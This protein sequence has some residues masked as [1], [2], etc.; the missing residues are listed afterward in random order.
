MSAEEK[1][2][3]TGTN[4]EPEETALEEATVLLPAN[5]M[6]SRKAAQE[7]ETVML[8]A[9]QMQPEE[10]AVENDVP[11]A[12]RASLMEEFYTYLMENKKWW[13]LPI[14]IMMFLFAML[15]VLVTFFPAMAPFIYPL[16]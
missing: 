1:N 2:H 4:K 14:F 5:F 6:E 9:E 10:T 16:I 11:E 12:R 8:S 13:M 15:F 7:E 3:H